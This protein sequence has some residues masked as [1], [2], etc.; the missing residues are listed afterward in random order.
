M[1]Y[2][3]LQLTLLRLSAQPIISWAVFD[4]LLQELAWV[5]ATA[6]CVQRFPLSGAI[7]TVWALPMIPGSPQLPGTLDVSAGRCWEPESFSS[8]SHGCHGHRASQSLSSRPHLPGPGAHISVSGGPSAEHLWPPFLSG[9][10]AT[11]GHQELAMRSCHRP[12]KL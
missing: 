6:R 12:E 10:G 2:R 11:G 1:P 7:F 8:E 3:T 5:R 9:H 4:E